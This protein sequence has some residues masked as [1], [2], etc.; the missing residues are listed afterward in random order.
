MSPTFVIS[1]QTLLEETNA[2]T[3]IGK[4]L[5]GDIVGDVESLFS[6]ENFEYLRQSFRGVF[7]F[8][9][10]HP[11]VDTGVTAY[12]LSGSLGSDSR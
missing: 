3:Q 9:G 2:D 1:L 6:P 8:L 11:E 12:L 10:F 4:N 7:A 5:T